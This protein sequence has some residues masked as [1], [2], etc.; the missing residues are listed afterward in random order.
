MGNND[1]KEYFK[2]DFELLWVENEYI[3]M[4]YVIR[5]YRATQFLHFATFDYIL[6][7]LQGFKE[8]LSDI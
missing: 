1:D 4:F 3:E 5:R 8:K 7:D 2:D 6:T